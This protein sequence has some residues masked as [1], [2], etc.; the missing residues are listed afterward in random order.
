VCSSDLGDPSGNPFRYTGRRYDAETGLYFYRARYYDPET[1]R[2]IQA[3]PIGYE[4][5]WNLYAYVGNNPLNGTDPTGMIEREV[6]RQ[7]QLPGSRIIITY[8]VT[9]EAGNL[10]QAETE[11]AFSSV[12][13]NFFIDQNGN[14]L[15]SFQKENVTGDNENLI[16][17]TQIAA[18]VVGSQIAKWDPRGRSGL[19]RAWRRVK[20]IH[21][22]TIESSGS[23]GSAQT[24]TNRSDFGKVI[25]RPGAFRGDAD[26]WSPSGTSLTKVLFHETLH[27]HSHYIDMVR[28]M[29]T[30]PSLYDTEHDTLD[31]QARAF[32]GLFGFW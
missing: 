18:Q 3:D 17:R 1:G 11:A 27:F 4:D 12:G 31:A 19:S 5:Q 6:E 14:N 13:D 16:D 24:R 15:S 22:T 20:E 25:L 23:L 30:I 2:F 29:D 9:V 8:K 7:V 10:S 26:V 32:S 21:A 28:H